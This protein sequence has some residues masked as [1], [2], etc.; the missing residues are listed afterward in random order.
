MPD[1]VCAGDQEG[2]AMIYEC[3]MTQ[4]PDAS[5]LWPVLL[6]PAKCKKCGT[7]AKDNFRKET[8]RTLFFTSKPDA[9]DF[10]SQL[11]RGEKGGK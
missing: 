2:E 3:R 11:Q 8:D 9:F 5:G 10:V 7:R 1:R 6:M 4:T